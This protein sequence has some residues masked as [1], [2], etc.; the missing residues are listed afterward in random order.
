MKVWT[1]K[2]KPILQIGS[3]LHILDESIL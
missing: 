3:K 1:S 2:G